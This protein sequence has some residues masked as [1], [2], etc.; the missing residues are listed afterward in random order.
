MLTAV[1]PM[2]HVGL[3]SWHQRVTTRDTTKDVLAL[4]ASLIEK[5]TSQ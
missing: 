5:Y 4:Q 1:S 2:R 3:A